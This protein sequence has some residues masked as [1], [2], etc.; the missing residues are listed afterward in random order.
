MVLRLGGLRFLMSFIECVGSLM[1]ERGLVDIMSFAF[2]GVD[3]N[4]DMHKINV[5]I[6]SV[7]CD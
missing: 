4:V 7:H 3:H 5:H 1:T 6:I 2:R